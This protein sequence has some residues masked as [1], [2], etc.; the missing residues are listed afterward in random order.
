[1]SDEQVS[2]KSYNGGVRKVDELKIR[3]LSL[4]SQSFVLVVD[5]GRIMLV[6][7]SHFPASSSGS[8]WWSRIAS[9]LPPA[10]PPS[11]TRKMIQRG[12]DSIAYN[13]AM[14]TLEYVGLLAIVGIGAFAFVYVILPRFIKQEPHEKD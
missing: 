4:S 2:E 10:I 12:V 13:R 1:M 6:C 8:L 9:S 7:S 11:S 5:S 14:N 3:R